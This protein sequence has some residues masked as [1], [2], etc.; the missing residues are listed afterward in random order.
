MDVCVCV[1][2]KD[3]WLP[4]LLLVTH[5]LKE[6]W[7]FRDVLFLSGKHDYGFGK[8]RSTLSLTNCKFPERLKKML[9]RQNINPD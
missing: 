3:S 4:V 8:Q 7:L 2:Y 1:E 5:G 6:K 9:K